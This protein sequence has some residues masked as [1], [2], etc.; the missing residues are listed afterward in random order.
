MS[1]SKKERIS[2][3]NAEHN[4]LLV[5]ATFEIY[6]TPLSEDSFKHIVPVAGLFLLAIVTCYLLSPAQFLP[7][8]YSF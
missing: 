6:S 3:G 7:T 8:F 4:I 2:S 5:S 1:N